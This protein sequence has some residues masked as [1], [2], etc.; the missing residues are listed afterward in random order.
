MP[1]RGCTWDS[2]APWTKG[3][4]PHEYTADI[5]PTEPEPWNHALVRGSVPS[6]MH[7]CFGDHKLCIHEKYRHRCQKEPSLRDGNI[8][9]ILKKFDVVILVSIL[10][11]NKTNTQSAYAL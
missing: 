3:V 10:S 1:K 11:A 6:D 5:G 2:T 4:V 9:Y 8:L 7:P